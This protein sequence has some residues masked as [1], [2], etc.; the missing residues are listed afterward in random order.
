MRKRMI[1]LALTAILVLFGSGLL[2][3]RPP[4]RD[5]LSPQ[6][7]KVVDEEA[8]RRAIA[9]A[10]NSARGV[11]NLDPLL[12]AKLQRTLAVAPSFAN[13][14]VNGRPSDW[15]ARVCNNSRWFQGAD[16]EWTSVLGPREALEERVV[17][18]SGMLINGGVGGDEVWY[19]HPF[20]NDWSGNL[21]LDSGYEFL[22]APGTPESDPDALA[23]IAAAPTIIGFPV[24][25]TLHVEFDSGLFPEN[26]R[27]LPGQEVVVF[28]RWIVDCGH[29]N[30][31]TEIHPPLL[32]VKSDGGDN[33]AAGITQATITSR[34]FLVTQTFNG[35][36]LPKHILD[37]LGAMYSIPADP[38][39]S[40]P[41][42]AATYRMQARPDIETVP[43]TG[44]KIMSFVM[45]PQFGRIS[46]SDRLL[47]RYQLKVRPG[48]AVQVVD[49][50]DDSITVW[51]VMNAAAY[52]PAQ[53][54]PPDKN[55]RHTITEIRQKLPEIANQIDKIR[56][57]GGIFALNPL[58]DAVLEKGFDTDSYI[59]PPAPDPPQLPAFVPISSITQGTGVT[60]STAQLNP[61]TG[62]IEL[63]WVRPCSP[64]NPCQA[65]SAVPAQ[66]AVPSNVLWV[67][68]EVNLKAGQHFRIQASGRWSNTGPPALGPDGFKGFLFQGTV[69]PSADL[70]SLIGRVGDRMFPI[71]ES[72]VGTS[73]V[74]GRLFLS[75]ND[76]PDTFADN[77]GTLAVKIWLQ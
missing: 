49:N 21:A 13:P 36:P 58:G 44:I 20:G 4:G 41:I 39:I 33:N 18:L 38:V 62:T 5:G 65:V 50:G 32:F 34:P 69:L 70:G 16:F 53:L 22:F 15:A 55:V 64:E 17:G 24:T 42:I 56:A 63:K 40:G 14:S 61:I 45:R 10:T 9:K 30:F 23:A 57:L 77:Q 28:G 8:R 11:E 66:I 27:P 46:A 19:T 43:F 72:L 6:A 31:T 60:T 73:P 74:S 12:L 3:Q 52:E 37:D 2:A 68:T 1:S 75:I 54:P 67:D 26:Y 71:G 47:V 51:I 7:R 48:V 76:T 59:L 35:F 25:N 29:T